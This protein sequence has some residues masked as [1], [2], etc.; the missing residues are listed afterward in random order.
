MNK[1]KYFRSDNFFNNSIEKAINP[2]EIPIENT[3]KTPF[4]FVKV[5]DSNP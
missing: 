2:K 5:N 1:N 3:T 4:N